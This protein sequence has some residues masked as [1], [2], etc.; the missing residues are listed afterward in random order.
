MGLTNI[1]LPLIPDLLAPQGR[2]YLVAVAQNKPLEIV[3]AMQG[4][5]LEA[6]VR[7]PL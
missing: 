1:V 7:A 4:L 3:A 6:E 5:G 2:F